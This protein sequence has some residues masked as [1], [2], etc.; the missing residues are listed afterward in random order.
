[1]PPVSSRLCSAV[2]RIPFVAGAGLLTIVS[3]TAAPTIFNATE[4][5][6]PGEIIGLQGASYGTAPVVLIATVDATGAVGPQSTLTPI[7]ASDTYVAAQI[8]STY[9]AGL[10]EVSV[11][12]ASSAVSA[13]VFINQARITSFEFPEIDSGRQFRLFGRNFLASGSTA[14]VRF[15]DNTTL[16]STA[17]TVVAGGSA[18]VASVQAPTGLTVG[19][20]YTVYYSNGAG[21][22]LGE[23]AAPVALTV[24]MGGSDPFSL[25]VPWGCDYASFASSVID[26]T[27]SPYN[28]DN[29]GGLDAT[30]AIQSAIDA[31]NSAGGGVVYLP[32]G[33]YKVATFGG[34]GGGVALTLKS[35]VVLQGAGASTT[36]LV[37]SAPSTVS[38][39]CGMI[40]AAAGAT[41][42]GIMDL[43]LTNAS[44]V[45]GSG[46]DYFISTS[47]AANAK[48]FVLRATLDGAY[49]AT[50]GIR[51]A[52]DATATNGRFLVSNCTLKNL[53]RDGRTISLKDFG[54]GANNCRYVDL[55]H[56]TIPNFNIG[57]QLGG[58]NVI[59][60]ANTLTF[61]G[62]YYNYIVGTLGQTQSD[63][64]QQNRINLSGPCNVVL[65]N[66]F[67]HAGA[68][69]VPQN[70]GENMLAEDSGPASPAVAKGT[71]SSG[72]ST[73][74]TDS[75]KSWTANAYVG[76][77]L[78]L[79][80]GPG[81]GEWRTVTGNAGTTLTVDSPWN[82]V[83]GSTNK[84][85]LVRFNVPHLLIDGNTITDK[86]HTTLLYQ[87]AFDVAVVNNTSTNSRD[88]W[89]R[90]LMTG[91]STDPAL[92]VILRV[93]VA[94]NTVTA[95]SASKPSVIEG[96]VFYK[97][98]TRFGVAAYLL[99][100]RRNSV[101][102]LDKD[103]YRATN[104]YRNSANQDVF[105]PQ[106]D[107]AP[108][109][110]QGVIYDGN[111]ATGAATAYGFYPGTL[112]TAEANYSAS[113]VERLD[114]DLTHR[115]ATWSGS[116]GW[117]AGSVTFSGSNYLDL[118][119]STIPT[120]IGTL[121]IPTTM[122]I[123][124]KFKTSATSKILFS[125][126][127][128]GSVVVQI[129]GS[130][131]L[132]VFNTGWTASLASSAALNDNTW[133]HFA[134]SS[135]GTTD[136]LYID[137]VL[138]QTSTTRTRSASTGRGQIGFEDGAASKFVGSLANLRVWNIVRSATDIAA[139]KDLTLA[140]DEP[141]LQQYWRFNESTGT[142]AH[143][144][145]LAERLAS[146]LV[147][148]WRLD[149]DTGTT[150]ADSSGT[151][152]AGTVNGTPAW[153]TGWYQ[154]ALQF[155]GST[156]Y[157][158]VPDATSLDMTAALTVHT[159]VRIDSISGTWNL[160]YRGIVSKGDPSNLC[161]GW[162][163]GTYAQPSTPTSVGFYFR[164]GTGSAA[165]TCYGTANLVT[166]QYYAVDVTWDAVTGAISLY[167]NGQVQATDTTASAMVASSDELDIGLRA[168]GGRYFDGVIDDAKVFDRVLSAGEI[169]ELDTP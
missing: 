137:G 163:L 57:L 55:T 161:T 71:V 70:D 164:R 56:N 25:G 127:P 78:L 24:R 72:T 132:A 151:G 74:L 111:K 63:S 16:T 1:M 97:E 86:E 23:V 7:T 21:G 14:T 87:G 13:A 19:H 64:G 18:Y 110:L 131:H 147:G 138:D 160:N 146:G 169:A 112:G 27:A 140:G 108:L 58:S 149:E 92:N 20:A 46:Y 95:T 17:G 91:A 113:G 99:E 80:D 156:N 36:S 145:T 54:T 124:G 125:N 126:R 117:A 150:A 43:T 76:F 62:D 153:V 28:A 135:T 115:D 88:I 84:Y 142:I 122:T 37:F 67:N 134:W 166:G 133:H 40:Q 152:N 158:A 136:L 53:R 109:A 75:T 33:T 12:D 128:I 118:T 90:T 69:F 168:A 102:S 4:S 105:H 162:E 35:N 107:T 121:T 130:G 48:L 154:N 59:Y 119:T 89:V 165:V 2:F 49:Y 6:A 50:G 144:A 98:S 123:E 66:T 52:V 47:G 167:V 29:T 101:T 45:T 155:D 68:A 26:V 83:P 32:A 65:N 73:T 77:N 103:A 9:A 11:Q 157:V 5:A 22:A 39:T 141:G 104:I 60:E 159:R 116:A 114:Y 143:N 93:L 106:G 139:T 82:V 44:T 94:D 10:Y 100:V 96:Q 38:A 81:T 41:T 8:P 51:L 15:V 42:M 148:Y 120:I 30:P 79:V 31:A 129:N 34:T 61:D 3:A 85:I